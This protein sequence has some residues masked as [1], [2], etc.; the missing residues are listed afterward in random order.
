MTIDVFSSYRD[1]LLFGGGS[2]GT[3]PQS[4]DDNHHSPE[5]QLTRLTK[6]NDIIPHKKAKKEYKHPVPMNKMSTKAASAVSEDSNN[7]KV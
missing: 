7:Q 1:A 2:R 3:T 5:S 6:G 4:S